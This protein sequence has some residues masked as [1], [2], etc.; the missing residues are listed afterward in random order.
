M[1]LTKRK[2]PKPELKPDG[3]CHAP[4]KD[5]EHCQARAVKDTWFCAFHR[6]HAAAKETTP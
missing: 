2:T 4:R 3:N 1:P 5:G 6:G